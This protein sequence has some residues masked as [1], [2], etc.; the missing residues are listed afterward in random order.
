MQDIK[1]KY[2]KTANGDYIEAGDQ[3]LPRGLACDGFC[4]EC[5]DKLV[6]RYG[7]IKQPHFAHYSKHP[8]T[9]CYESSLHLA[10]K[11]KILGTV[12]QKLIL[13][14][15]EV[16]ERVNPDIWRC[17]VHFVVKSALEEHTID[18][19]NGKQIRPDV[20][21]TDARDREVIVE[22]AVTNPKDNHYIEQIKQNNLM[23]IEF[24]TD[25]KNDHANIPDGIEIVSKS[26]WLYEPP[27][28]KDLRES[29]T[30]Y[31]KHT[32]LKGLVHK[33]DVVGN[34]KLITRDKFGSNLYPNV[35]RTLNRHARQLVVTGFQQ[36]PSRPTLF[37][38]Q[39]DKWMIYADLGG[40][41]IVKIWEDPVPS[42]YAF[43]SD[44]VEREELLELVG[45]ILEYRKIPY[46]R[47]FEDR[48]YM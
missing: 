19:P 8:T 3:N 32:V 31:L 17:D 18:L 46:R 35:R 1:I 10:L 11:W 9:S 7:P 48:H 23:A 14:T 21:L 45:Y 34:L 28:S 27:F 25:T 47:H 37:M 40:T 4:P 5:G 29:T 43:P 2:A 42:I 39:S 12:G 38:Y 13:P 44:L 15:P 20:L 41:E 22:I 16:A 33:R 36:Q 24:R 30:D 26:R 6:H